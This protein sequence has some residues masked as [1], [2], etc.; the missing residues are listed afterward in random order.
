MKIRAVS[1]RVNKPENDDPGILEEGEMEP[2]GAADL[3]VVNRERK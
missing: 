2:G 1:R 3:T